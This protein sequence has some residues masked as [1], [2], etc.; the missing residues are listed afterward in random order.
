MRSM[1]Y[2]KTA[3]CDVESNYVMKNGL[4]IGC[5]HGLTNSD[6][7]YISKTFVNF[8]ELKLKKN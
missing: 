4:L 3:N 5:H 7:S 6:L 2:A 1:K 8:L